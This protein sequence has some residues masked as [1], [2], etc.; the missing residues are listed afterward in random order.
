MEVW[1]KILSTLPPF[2]LFHFRCFDLYRF[3]FQ[4]LRFEKELY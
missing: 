4:Y 1:N 3:Y 2:F